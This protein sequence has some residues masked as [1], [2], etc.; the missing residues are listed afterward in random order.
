LQHLIILNA[1]YN[2]IQ[3]SA[4]IFF[5]FFTWLIKNSASSSALQDAESA[6]GLVH[7]VQIFQNHANVTHNV[8]GLKDKPDNHQPQ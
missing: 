2:I 1:K 3:E 7:R 5:I 4:I 6:H 8:D